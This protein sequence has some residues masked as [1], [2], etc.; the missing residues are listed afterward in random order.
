M[1]PLSVHDLVS[2]LQATDEFAVLDCREEGDFV[3]AH[4]FA[5][6]NLPFSRLELTLATAVP[7][8]STLIVFA[9]DLG[10]AGARAARLAAKM[11]YKDIRVLQGGIAAWQASGLPLF[12]G[13]NVPG[14]AFGEY[15]ERDLRPPSISAEALL[16]RLDNGQPTLLLDTRSPEE[17]AH[18]CIPG[19]IACPNGELVI[20]ALEA[21]SGKDT[22]VVTHCGGRT[23][24]IIGAQT[25]KDLGLKQPVFALENGTIGWEA[26]GKALEHGSDRTLPDTPAGRA[27]GRAAA[28][29]LGHQSGIRNIDLDTLRQYQRDAESVTYLIDV[30]SAQEFAAGHLQR[31]WHVP[32]GQLIQTIDRYVVVRNARIVLTDDDAARATVIAFWLMRMGFPKVEVLAATAD[33]L[34]ARPEQAQPAA[35]AR[36]RNVTT[37][38]LVLDVRPSP[39][40]R[41]G[42]VPGS[43]FLT[44]ENLDRDVPN[45][46]ETKQATLITDDQR[47]AQLMARDLERFGIDA[48]V[49]KGG[50]ARWIEEGGTPESGL[51]QLASPPNDTAYF[52]DMHEDAAAT[53]REDRRYIAWETALIDDMFDDPSIRYS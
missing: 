49:L 20:R 33:A 29:A 32:G 22:T 43:W 5:A 8:R 30:R 28:E 2:L 7:N 21:V 4:L 9:D 36:P 50:Y 18:Y 47:Y 42:H 41:D 3:H 14:K 6:T 13:V 40:F 23:R 15:V 31:A 1:T 17:H 16:A 38:G 25:L 34:S 11:G 35:D 27:T 19:A 24:S 52:G 12:S 45:L 39:Q 26:I 46:P 51:T 48:K 10:G 53:A 44:R 37:D